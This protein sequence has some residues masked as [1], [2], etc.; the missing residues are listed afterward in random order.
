MEDE[1]PSATKLPQLNSLLSVVDGQP[2]YQT[3]DTLPLMLLDRA[4]AH[5]DSDVTY[6]MDDDDTGSD[7]HRQLY[8]IPQRSLII[9]VLDE[10]F[11]AATTQYHSPSPQYFPF[12]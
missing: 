5:A 6:K 11:L 3:A 8:F 4:Y 10:H 1:R 7:L 9:V 2:E 12:N